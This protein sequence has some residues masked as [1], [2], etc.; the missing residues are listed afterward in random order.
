MN[1]FK[2]FSPSNKKKNS[3][4]LVSGLPRSGTSLM[5]KMLSMGGME[6]LVDNIRTADDDNPKGYFEYE[7]VKALRNGDTKWL[8]EA[9]GKAVK[10]IFTLLPYLPRDYTYRAIFMRREMAEILASQKKML[11]RRGEDPDK[12]SDEEISR[13]YEKHMREVYNW[14]DSQ[15]NLEFIDVNYNELVRDPPPVIKEINTFLGGQLD[16][17]KMASAVDLNLYRQRK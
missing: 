9:K 13:L 16:S 3:I 1:L 7:R 12:V 11:I 17:E 4:T 14:A 15:K 6:P 10:I 2:K 5:M 8:P